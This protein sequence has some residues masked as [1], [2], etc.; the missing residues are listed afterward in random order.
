LQQSDNRDAA[1]I[2]AF[3]M[4]AARREELPEDCSQAA[5]QQFEGGGNFVYQFGR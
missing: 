1:I 5:A 2:K 3:G 4:E